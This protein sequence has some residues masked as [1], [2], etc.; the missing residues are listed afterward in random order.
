MQ[1]QISTLLFVGLTCGTMMLLFTRFWGEWALNG[2][3]NFYIH[4]FCCGVMGHEIIDA[5]I[6]R[7]RKKQEYCFFLILVY[8]V[9]ATKRFLI[10]MPKIAPCQF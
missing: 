6:L 7:V 1:H 2:N 9:Q 10:F 8:V 4:L 5:D 3:K